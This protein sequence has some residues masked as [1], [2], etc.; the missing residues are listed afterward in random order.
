MEGL[1]A[2]GTAVFD[3]IPGTHQIYQPLLNEKAED[4]RS[5]KTE[6]YSYGPN[7]RQMLDVYYP[8][9]DNSTS[10]ILIFFYGGGLVR[11]DRMTPDG[12]L[13]ANLG[14]FFSKLG[15]I[16]IIPDYRLVPEAK[17]PSGGEDV[18]GS[19]Q[20]TDSH[21][22]PDRDIYMMGNSAGGVHISTFLLAEDFASKRPGFVRAVGGLKGA[23][24][25]STPFS[26]HE[27]DPSRKPVLDAY[28]GSDVEN[29]SPVGLLKGLKDSASLFSVPVL[30]LTCSLDP[31][32][33]IVKP[34]MEFSDLY[35]SLAGDSRVF[36]AKVVEGHNHISPVCA[37]G[38]S[39]EADEAWGVDVHQWMRS[40]STNN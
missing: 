18:L 16:T 30:V 23:I 9:G 28:F 19:L 25:L 1:P 12:L 17:F 15:Y 31:V 39:R 10:P 29:K 32:D 2:L 38:T 4:I 11:G 34:G 5:T 26:F 7:P 24:L 21:F 40:L 8:T 14:H 13:Y 27:A 22:G 35:K 33:E 37:L 6:T 20:W 36:E 3:I